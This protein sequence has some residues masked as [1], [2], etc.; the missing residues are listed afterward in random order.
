M[1]TNRI[2]ALVLSVFA[3]TLVNSFAGAI[4]KTCPVK[5]KAAS[6]EASVDVTFCCDKCK[7]KFDKDPVAYMEKVADAKEGKCPMSGKDVDAAQKSTITVGVCCD[8]C[9]KKVEADPKKYLKD[10]KKD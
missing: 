5:G 7:A 10:V 4:N 1:K 3:L 8:G 9:K 2:I 6:K